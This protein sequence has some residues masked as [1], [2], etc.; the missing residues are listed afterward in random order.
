MNKNYVSGR[1]FEY[2]VKDYL[3]K[4]G[5]YV[6]RSAGSKS[7]FD[8]IAIQT[9]GKSSIDGTLLIQCKHR[10]KISKQERERL[11]KL[12]HTFV[13]GI[14]C[15]CAWSKSHGKIEFYRW[16]FS[17]TEGKYIWIKTGVS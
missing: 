11:L 14:S 9:K 2:R 7:P 5:Y 16:D 12:S 4:K 17:T 8:L 3:E 6:M 13:R 1:R 10:T 15:L